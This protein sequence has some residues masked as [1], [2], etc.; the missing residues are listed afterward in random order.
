VKVRRAHRISGK[1]TDEDGGVPENIR[2]L[3]VLAWF[4]RDDGAGYENEQGRV[5]RRDGSYLIDGLVGK[6]V[7]IMAINWRAAKQGNAHPPIYYPGTFSRND[8]KL[9]TFDG[10]QEI[11]NINITPQ[12]EGGLVLR[13]AVTDETGKPVPE[14]FVVVHRRDMLVDFVTDY[15]DARGRYQ[16]QGLAEGEFLVHVDAVHRGFVRTR[17][18][19]DLD[20][21]NRTTQQDFELKQGVMISGKLVD[22]QDNAWQIGESYGYANIKDRKGPT[23]S[24]SLTNFRNKYRPE[25]AMRSSGGSFSPGEGDYTGGQMLFPTESTFVIQGMMPGNTM[26][27]FSPKKERTEV[28]EILHN[29]RNI[30]ETGLETT[31]GQEI[32][33]VKIVIATR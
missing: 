16:I 10:K 24:F 23:S 9:I 12:K 4:E 20:S 2:T 27:G 1:V 31:A 21:A 3:R 6:P 19:V 28:S 11:D 14:A 26:I 15:T 29:G 30:M 5:N 25:N 18:P 33:D 32:K 8:A 17:I 22:E 7:Y 13:G